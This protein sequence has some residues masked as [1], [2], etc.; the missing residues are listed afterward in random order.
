VKF[1]L[2]TVDEEH[3]ASGD[4]PRVQQRDAVHANLSRRGAQQWRSAIDRG[5]DDNASDN[6]WR[7]HPGAIRASAPVALP[8]ATVLAQAASAAATRGRTVAI[9]IADRNSWRTA[10]KKQES[11][12]K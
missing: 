1:I 6:G 12:V 7:E 2:S 9:V 3:G 5:W 4:A 10:P 8:M 11:D